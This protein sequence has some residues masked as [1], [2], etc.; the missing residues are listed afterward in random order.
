MF[1]DGMGSPKK[2]KSSQTT[3]M[4]SLTTS[5]RPPRSALTRD[6]PDFF[7]EEYDALFDSP[8]PPEIVANMRD[9]IETRPAVLTPRHKK[10]LLRMLDF[11]WFA[12]FV[13]NEY[14]HDPE[15]Q[16]LLQRVVAK[17]MQD[18]TMDLATLAFI[19]GDHM[20]DVLDSLERRGLIVSKTDPQNRTK[21]RVTA[22]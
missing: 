17:K 5:S 1:S 20:F 19:F 4:T 14:E 15:M 16:A 7:L 10:A 22:R 18:E 9:L 2:E 3:I 21:A 8:P 6:L 12:R 13:F 11:R